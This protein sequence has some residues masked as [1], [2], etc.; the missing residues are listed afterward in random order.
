MAGPI[1]V[2]DMVAG[3]VGTSRRGVRLA[4]GGWYVAEGR[5]AGSV[6][7]GFKIL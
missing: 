4:G 3:W 5:K 1:E 2:R 7:S 6:H